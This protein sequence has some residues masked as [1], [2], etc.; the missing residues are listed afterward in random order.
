MHEQHDNILKY[1][2]IKSQ[3]AQTKFD[4][5]TS[6]NLYNYLF[7]G[8]NPIIRPVVNSNTTINITFDLSLMQLIN[9]VKIASL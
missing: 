1:L 7:T 4:N 6:Y 8:Y 9:I 5:V 2:F 3:K